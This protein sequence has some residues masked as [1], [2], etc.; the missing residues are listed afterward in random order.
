MNKKCLKDQGRV[1]SRVNIKVKRINKHIF[2][3]PLISTER[4]INLIQKHNITLRRK[5]PEKLIQ[6]IVLTKILLLSIFFHSLRKKSQFKYI[7]AQVWYT[8]P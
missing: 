7:L 2:F 5:C 1:R 4:I 6:H 3:S 8:S